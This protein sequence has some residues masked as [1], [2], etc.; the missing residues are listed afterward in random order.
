MRWVF[1][2]ETD[3]SAKRLLLASNPELFDSVTTKQIGWN[4]FDTARM[5]SSDCRMRIL[6]GRDYSTCLVRF[7]KKVIKLV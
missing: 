1:R 3:E 4:E 2:P 6:L 7:C 5:R